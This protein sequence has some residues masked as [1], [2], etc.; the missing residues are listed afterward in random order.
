MG[1]G[2][3]GALPTYPYADYIAISHYAKILPIIRTIWIA[4]YRAG[5][6]GAFRA[7]QCEVGDLGAMRQ[8]GSWMCSLRH[9][10]AIADFAPDAGWTI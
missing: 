9:W 7:V 2:S 5:A 10:K 6:D 1:L 8:R 3:T 4:Q